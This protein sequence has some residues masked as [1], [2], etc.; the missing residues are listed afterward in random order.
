VKHLTAAEK[1]A[2]TRLNEVYHL[3]RGQIVGNDPDHHADDMR[4]VEHYIHGLQG[5]LARQG[6]AR[7]DPE[8]WRL[9]GEA[10]P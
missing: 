7:A 10:L 9:L 6:M 1:L 2:M 4:E 8:E 3:F 5:L